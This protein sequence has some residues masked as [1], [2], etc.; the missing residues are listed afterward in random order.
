[1]ETADVVLDTGRQSVHCLVRK[2]EAVLEQ[3]AG[4]A[5]PPCPVVEA[6][7]ASCADQPLDQIGQRQ[8]GP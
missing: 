1:M 6:L 8:P 7:D 2:L 3:S 5:V 4:E